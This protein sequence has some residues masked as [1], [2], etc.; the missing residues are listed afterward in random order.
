MKKFLFCPVWPFSINQRFGENKACIPI[1]G[2]VVV[3]CDGKNPPAGYKSLYGPL[4]HKGLDLAS[5]HGQP[6][7]CACAGVVA[8]IDTDPRSGLDVRV[9]SEVDGKRYRHIYE[10]L[11]GYQAKVGD[12]IELGQ[13]IGWADNT[14]YSS[15]DHLHWQFEVWDGRWIAIDPLPYTEFISAVQFA[16]LWRQVKE[17]AARLAEYLADKLHK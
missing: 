11:L 5:Y 6:V 9:I 3:S 1:Q 12:K 7:Y 4:G 16:G 14:G 15:G 17:L 10:H 2:G 8:S 13:L